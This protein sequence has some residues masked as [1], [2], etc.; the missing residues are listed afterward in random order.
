MKLD[1][2]KILD[3]IQKLSSQGLS[4]SDT[5]FEL[6]GGEYLNDIF[7]QHTIESIMRS[8]VNN[9]QLHPLVNG[10][11]IDVLEGLLNKEIIGDMEQFYNLK[12]EYI[13]T[14]SPEQQVLMAKALAGK[15]KS[16]EEVL[17]ASWEKGLKTCACG[18]ESEHRYMMFEVDSDNANQVAI[19]QQISGCCDGKMQIFLDKGKLEVTFYGEG[20]EFYDKMKD[21]IKLERQPDMFTVTLLG[22]VNDNN[23]FSQSIIDGK[24]NEIRQLSQTLEET[25]EENVNLQNE[26]QALKNKIANIKE[27]ITKRLAKIPLVGKAILRSMEKEENLLQEKNE[28]ER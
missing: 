18:G 4:R 23:D 5:L 28:V 10:T 16:Q 19:M 1:E 25:L 11:G 2:N 14:L 8:F 7:D 15:N 22:A 24:E 27:W 26:N 9:N 20:E 6:L 3:E 13:L 21:A 17:I 12:P